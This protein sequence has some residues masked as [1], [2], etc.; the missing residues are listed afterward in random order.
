MAKPLPFV[1]Q[2]RL[3]PVETRIGSEESGQF[4][5]QRR[6]YLNVAEKSFVQ[7]ALRSDDAPAALARTVADIARK[8][9]KQPAEVFADMQ[10]MESESAE[11]QYLVAYQSEL[12]EHGAAL[13]AYTE[14]AKLIQATCLLMQRHDPSWGVED[15]L[16]LHPDI[17]EGLHRLYEDEDARCVDELLAATAKKASPVQ[18]EE[19]KE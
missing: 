17:I 8:E 4:V 18:E 1:V 19:G 11:S 10:G 7:E 2:P 9:G 6:G 15:T 5:I 3:E 13:S 14:R 16:A 12:A